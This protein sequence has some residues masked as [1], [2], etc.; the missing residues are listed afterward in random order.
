MT[1]TSREQ[2]QCQLQVLLDRAFGHRY[3]MDLQEFRAAVFERGASDLVFFP[4][5]IMHKKL[6]CAQ[7]IFRIKAQFRAHNMHE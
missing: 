3:K 4:L 5:H 2:E 6:P 7:N 1:L